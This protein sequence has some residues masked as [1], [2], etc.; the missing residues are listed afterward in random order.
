MSYTISDELNKIGSLNFRGVKKTNNFYDVCLL[1]K[2]LHRPLT[3]I[4]IQT[5]GALL[6][7]NY[8]SFLKNHVWVSV[9][10]ISL[11]SFDDEENKLICIPARTIRTKMNGL[12]VI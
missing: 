9:V 7:E 11:S 4:E 2:L 3:K 1:N 12:E 8:L 6:D 10:S 5:T